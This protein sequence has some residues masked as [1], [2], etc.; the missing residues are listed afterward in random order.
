M[1]IENGNAENEFQSL[2]AKV[3][4]IPAEIITDLDIQESRLKGEIIFLLK[5][6]EVIEI[7]LKRLNL[8]GSSVRC[9]EG[10]S[11]LLS[12]NLNRGSEKIKCS[13]EGEINVDFKMKFHYP[14]ITKKMVY[15]HPQARDQDYFNPYVDVAKGQLY[16][17]FSSSLN[18]ISENFLQRQE[19]EK[20]TDLN[21]TI[22]MSATEYP[23]VKKIEVQPCLVDLVKQ[24]GQ[25]WLNIQPVFIRD[26][27][28]YQK[29][30]GWAFGT[31]MQNAKSIWGKCG[32]K[33]DILDPI[34]VENA[35]YKVLKNR[36]EVINLKDEVDI[37]DAIEIFVVTRFD[38]I[39]WGGGATFDSGTANAKIVTCDEQLKVTDAEG[40]Y[41]G[42]INM[43]HLAHELGHVLGLCH[44]DSGNPR[45]LIDGTRDT[46]MNV[47]GFYADNPSKQSQDNCDN[48][49]NALLYSRRRNHQYSG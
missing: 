7:H 32:I 17:K 36:T 31:M 45:S 8:L 44:P 15:L 46:V 40:K 28:N 10:N 9:K 35:S 41:L 43:N 23:W 3:E 21:F 5:K 6:D 47:S 25:N 24:I 12:L 33:F 11:G 2:I 38:P 37:E 20:I 29:P 16:G 34:Y 48:A 30:T 26:G 13:T 42:A 49:D 4:N 39:R 18:K 19:D 1:D 22:K 27:K 14:L